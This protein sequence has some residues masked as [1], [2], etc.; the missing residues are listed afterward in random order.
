MFLWLGQVLCGS[1][2]LRQKEGLYSL[3]QRRWS[4][5]PFSFEALHFT[6]EAHLDV[7]SFKA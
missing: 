3:G 5:P 6:F 7:D 4:W 2:L 1:Q